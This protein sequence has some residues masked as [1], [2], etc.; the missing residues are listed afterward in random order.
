MKRRPLYL[1][2]A[3]RFLWLF[4]LTPAGRVLVLA[5]LLTALGSVT[6]QLPIYQ[7]F[8]GLFALL[9]VAETSGLLFKPSLR[10]VGEPPTLSSAGGTVT[11]QF[12]LHNRSRWRPA[13]DVMLGLFGLPRDVKHVSGDLFL[14]SIRPGGEARLSLTLQ[15][16]RRGIFPLP[17]VQAVSTFPFNLVRFGGGKT[18]PG[19]L[20]VLPDYHSL[21]ELEIPVSYRYQPGGVMLTQGVGHSPEFIGNREY[22]PGE[23]VRRIDSRAWARLGRPVV[24][25]FHEEYVSR[26]ALVLDTHLPAFRWPDGANR[27]RLEAAVSL[28][29]AIAERLNFNEHVIDLFAAGPELYVFRTIT[30][31]THFDSVLEILA[32]IEPSRQNPFEKISP[33]VVEELETIST[34]VCVLVGWDTTRAEFVRRVQ[35]SGCQIKGVLIRDPD[36]NSQDGPPLDL[37]GDWTIA[38]AEQIASGELVRL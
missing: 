9:G 3:S 31:T 28:M 20:V 21:E 17:A 30:G 23:S 32:G 15:T 27:R 10:I 22:T 12:V 36:T 38:T 6:T 37:D 34:A 11:T 8:C 1:Y 7:L 24:K 18:E 5:I 16:D 35:E 29:A 33:L 26:I 13:L 19:R 14:P 4:K 2:R 25:E